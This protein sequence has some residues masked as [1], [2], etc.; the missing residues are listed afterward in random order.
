MPNVNYQKGYK[1]YWTP[2]AW[3]LSVIPIGLLVGAGFTEVTL[4]VVLGI[5]GILALVIGY[6]RTYKNIKRIKAQNQEQ[7][8]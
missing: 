1:W 7:E 3:Y 8:E 6:Y 5:T 2:R 4:S